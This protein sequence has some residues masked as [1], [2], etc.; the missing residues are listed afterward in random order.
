MTGKYIYDLDAS[1]IFTLYDRAREARQGGIPYPR[2]AIIYP[3]Y[4]C[5]YE[6]VGCEY[7]NMN[8]RENRHMDFP[9]LSKL[10]EELRNMGV[11]SLEFCGGGEP[12]LYRQL[13]NIITY[14][15]QLGFS[16]GLLTNGSHVRGKLAQTIA[17]ELSYVRISLDAATANTYTLTKRPAGADFN[18]IITQ[19]R[20]LIRLRHQAKSQLLISIK[21]LVSKMNRHDIPAVFD[22]AG[23]LQVDSLQF[24]ALRQSTAKL[25]PRQQHL[26]ATQINSLKAAH[27]DLKVLGGVDKLTAR[28]RCWITPLQTVIDAKGDVFL[29]CYY[30]HRRTR[31]CIGNIYK[32]TFREIWEGPR[33]KRAIA[34]IRPVEC[35]LFDCRFIHY[36]KVLDP[37]LSDSRHQIDFI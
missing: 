36:M 35:N 19:I 6:C 26:V 7:S 20:N 10:L 28:C 31:H 30:L 3:N 13:D 5:N 18:T 22:L 37:L 15:R 33:H 4:F 25:T 27:P 2:M 32:N 1:R 29:C 14:G 16:I 21:F 17:R 24:K 34:D 23:D 9:R 11:D 8:R 12:T